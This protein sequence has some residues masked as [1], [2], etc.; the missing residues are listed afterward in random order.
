[1]IFDPF[2]PYIRSALFILVFYVMAGTCFAQR[3][4]KS[5]EVEVSERLGSTI[6]QS[7]TFLRSDSVLCQPFANPGKPVLITL[8]VY[9]CPENCD[10]LPEGIADLINLGKMEP[11]KDYLAYTFSYDPSESPTDAK[12][13]RDSM[14]R[15]LRKKIPKEGWTFYTGINGSVDSLARMLGIGYILRG[16]HFFYPHLAVLIS[17][18]GKIVKYLYGQL[19]NVAE[20]KMALEN[21]LQEE[22][23]PTFV[24]K[25]H[26]CLN[27]DP[28]VYPR[29][30]F[31]LHTSMIILLVTLSVVAVFLFR[32]S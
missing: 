7:L 3:G 10:A 22:T 31:I 27:Y 5:D 13:K 30:R 9:Q 23:S 12:E 16:N 29:Y 25:L 28:A 26:Y 1:M 17:P 24:K 32:K 18:N 6:P 8:M 14:F 20:F 11:G 4:M 19:F 2:R 15:L 21:A